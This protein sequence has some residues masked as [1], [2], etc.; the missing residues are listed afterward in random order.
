MNHR[1]FRLFSALHLMSYAE[2]RHV[3]VY[4]CVLWFGYGFMK[5]RAI[6]RAAPKSLYSIGYLNWTQP[7]LP[8]EYVSYE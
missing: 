1:M 4:F 6:Y 2:R 3:F 8:L 5:L 7:L